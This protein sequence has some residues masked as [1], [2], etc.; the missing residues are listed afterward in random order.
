MPFKFIEIIF[1]ILYVLKLSSNAELTLSIVSK[2]IYF[3]AYALTQAK[4]FSL[5]LAG[6]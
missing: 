3:S 4:L 1:T 5:G 6:I 2:Q